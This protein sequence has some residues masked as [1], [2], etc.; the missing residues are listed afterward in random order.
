MTRTTPILVACLGALGLFLTATP[1]RA[2]L[3]DAAWNETLTLTT[4]LGTDYYPGVDPAVPEPQVGSLSG[5]NYGA[6]GSVTFG[7]GP[8]NVTSSAN[9]TYTS[10]ITYLGVTSYCRIDFQFAVRQTSAPPVAVTTVP[11][12]VTVQGTVGVAGGI[13]ASAFSTVNLATFQGPIAS[14]AAGVDNSAGTATDGFN[15]TVQIDLAPD[16]VVDGDM[17][18]DAGIAGEVLVTGTFATASSWVD[19]VIAVAD[20]TIPGSSDSYRDHYEIEFSPGYYALDQSPV[21][22]TTWGKIKRLYGD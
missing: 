7:S 13:F 21:E 18:A 15:E 4:N 22:R 17:T 3:S 10:G 6:D 5:T 20:E 14:W 16:L 9:A 11:V 19:P 2:Q 1:I 12:N 8:P